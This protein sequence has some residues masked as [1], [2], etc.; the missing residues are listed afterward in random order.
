VVLVVTG[1][2]A[3][4]ADGWEE[5]GVLRRQLPHW[6]SA[7]DMRSIVIGFEPAADRHGGVGAFYVRLRSR[8]LRKDPF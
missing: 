6:L 4:H 5:R 7:L 8:R 2:G 3:P 1:K